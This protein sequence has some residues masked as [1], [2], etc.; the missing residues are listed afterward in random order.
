MRWFT[1]NVDY[2]ARR[3]TSFA[4]IP[5]RKSPF[6]QSEVQWKCNFEMLWGYEVNFGGLKLC[7]FTESTCT[8][9]VAKI[10]MCPALTSGTKTPADALTDPWNFILESWSDDFHGLWCAAVWEFFCVFLLDYN[11]VIWFQD[12]AGDIEQRDLEDGKKLHLDINVLSFGTCF[13]SPSFRSAFPIVESVLVRSAHAGFM[14]AADSV[15]QSIRP[16]IRPAS[17]LQNLGRKWT[18]W[19]ESTWRHPEIGKHGKHLRPGIC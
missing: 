3:L 7:S 16:A 1:P 15:L 17:N 19:N 5:R 18:F 2:E 9:V 8:D 10:D 6:C 13:L 12:L 4:L 11:N 14:T